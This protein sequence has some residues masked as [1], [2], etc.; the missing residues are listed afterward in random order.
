MAD[1]D[2]N[3]DLVAELAEEF[4]ERYRAG[5][6]PPLSEYIDNYPALADEI[7]DVFPALV[8]VENLAPNN[9]E[10][11]F[12]AQRQQC[13]IAD[14]TEIRQL[15]EYR[16]IREVG[17]GGMGVVYEAEQ[18][19]L[20]RRVALKVLAPKLARDGKFL[21]RFK[22]EAQTV[23]ALSHQNVVTL[24]S[25]EESAGTHFL[26]MELV[27]GEPLNHLIPPGGFELMELLLKPMNTSET[28]E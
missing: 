13:D 18:E 1:S 9:D 7:R 16:I 17:R 6:R 14:S 15:G 24:H 23:A 28:R 3:S 25:V 26:T 12:D 2:L 11:I 5:E 8:M 27:R 22:R 20:G 21:S 4:V 19:S 10:S